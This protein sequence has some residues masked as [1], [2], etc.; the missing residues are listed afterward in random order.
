MFTISA[1]DK[2]HNFL[3]LD[4]STDSGIQC[5]SMERVSDTYHQRTANAQDPETGET[6]SQ[7]R[8]IAY[9]RTAE[10]EHTF[11]IYVTG[12]GRRAGVRNYQ[13]RRPGDRDSVII[14]GIKPVLTEP[15]IERHPTTGELV[16]VVGE[17]NPYAK[18][19]NDH[20]ICIATAVRA[21]KK[22]NIWSGYKILS[23][24]GQPRVLVGA[25]THTVRLAL[26][27][28]VVRYTNS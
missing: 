22:Y 8:R 26:K 24:Y 4:T 2:N 19:D 3:T 18:D 16:L 1:Y 27:E 5:E 21:T 28:E 9:F 12:Y 25:T 23:L 11:E 15:R 14:I 17:G 10:D 20:G 13:V 7:R 6:T